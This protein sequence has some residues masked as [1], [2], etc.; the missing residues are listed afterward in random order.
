MSKAGKVELFTADGSSRGFYSSL[1]R[2]N[3]LT[4]KEW[5]Y[6]S[7]SV[8]NK[9]YPPNMQ[10]RLRSQHG[11]QKPPDLCADLIKVFTKEG[12]LVLDPLAGVGGTL[13]GAALC[14]R[15]AVGI[16]LDSR[17]I[18]I[19]E[20]VCRLEELNAQRFICGNSRQVLPQLAADG[21]VFDFI[22]TD[23]PYWRMDKAEKSKGRYKK[24]GEVSKENRKSRLS[25]FEQVSYQS[26]AE[27]LS[28]LKGVF[29]KAVPLLKTDGYLAVFIGDMYNQ[30]RY[31]FLSAD[32]ACMLEDIGLTLKANIVWYDVSKSLH[33]YGY[34]YQ[35]IPSMIHQNILVLR[36]EG[37]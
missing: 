5:V 24:A 27:W 31:H 30:G 7:K 15:N 32:L 16:E 28:D 6:W 13:L 22:L 18:E 2:L 10:H 23:V 12:A 1:N 35:Y 29:S 17:Y 9:Q 11:G 19:Y 34:Q 26:K 4:G 21:V 25:P 14:R 37:A 36:K 20:E 33:V 8:I 3:E